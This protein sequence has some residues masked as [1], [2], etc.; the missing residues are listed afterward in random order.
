VEARVGSNDVDCIHGYVCFLCGRPA[1]APRL[2][3]YVGVLDR[4]TATW[5]KAPMARGAGLSQSAHGTANLNR[6]MQG[7]KQATAAPGKKNLFISVCR[8]FCQ[9]DPRDVSSDLCSDLC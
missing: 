2:S 6:A 4:S 5:G 3:A 9:R 7:E 1:M 8:S